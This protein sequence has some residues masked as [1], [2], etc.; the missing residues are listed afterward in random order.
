MLLSDIITLDGKKISLN[1][2]NNERTS[3][4]LRKQKYAEK[5]KEIGNHANNDAGAR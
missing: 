1:K 4:E 3:K 5:N 2:K